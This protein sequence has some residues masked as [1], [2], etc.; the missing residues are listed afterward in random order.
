MEKV[1]WGQKGAA[2]PI[3]HEGKGGIPKEWYRPTQT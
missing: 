1:E 3:L 2:E